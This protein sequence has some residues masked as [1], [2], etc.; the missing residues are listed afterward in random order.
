MGG[1][2]LYG[3]KWHGSF[4]PVSMGCDA[5]EDLGY[6]PQTQSVKSERRRFLS[7]TLVEFFSDISFEIN[8]SADV[9]HLKIAR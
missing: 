9:T 8:P 4:P 7:C 3:V 6:R 5:A 2:S 1:R